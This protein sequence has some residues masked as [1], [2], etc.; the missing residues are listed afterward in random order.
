[1]ARISTRVLHA[2]TEIAGQLM[3]SVVGQRELGVQATGFARPHSFDYQP[4]P[5]IVPPSNRLDYIRAAARTI[6]AHDL[7]HFY[8]GQSFLPR[9]L[10]AAWL[11]RLGKRVV[12]EFLGS[13]VRMP[14]VEA[15][16]NPYY[17]QSQGEDDVRATRVMQTWS[18]VTQGH[19]IVGDHSLDAFLAPRFPHIHVVG[20][21][22]DVQALVPAPPSAKAQRMRVIHA[23]THRAAKGTEFVRRAA[24][25]VAA[26]GAPIDYVE[27]EGL[28]HAQ[29]LQVYR[30]AD[31]IVDQLCCGGYGVFAAEAMSLAKPVVC[32]LLPEL[33]A[34]YPAGLPIINANPLTLE[35]VL[36]EWADQPHER[37]QRGLA[38]RAYAERVHDYRI[39]ARR[40]LEV[41]EM[42]PRGLGRGSSA[43][44]RRK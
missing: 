31:L 16:R 18:S 5:D 11:T 9:Q 19:V 43:G 36:A 6:R 42:L 37:H 13:D 44:S 35:H 1:M 22:V 32:Y 40:L 25:E 41:Y 8:F 3:L 27:I 33:E 14:S 30:S 12:V 38:S 24:A 21:R 2:P 4:A 26:A 20:Q 10:D 7:I 34:Q 28:P 15:Q 39:V 17:V 23:P 29:A